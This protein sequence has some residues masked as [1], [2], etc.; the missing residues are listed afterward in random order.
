MKPNEVYGRDFRFKGW[1]SVQT[2]LTLFGV[3]KS[4]RRASG[5]ITAHARVEGSLRQ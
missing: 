4:R 2:V 1:Q 3:E 5:A